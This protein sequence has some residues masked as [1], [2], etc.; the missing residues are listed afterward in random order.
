MMEEL[1]QAWIMLKLGGIIIIPLVLLGILV[2]SKDDIS[3][4]RLWFYNTM[5]D[6]VLFET[7]LFLGSLGLQRAF[8]ITSDRISLPTDYSGVTVVR[9]NKKNLSSN[10]D[11]IIAEIEKTKGSYNLKPLPAAALAF[12]YFENF[13]LPFGAKHYVN[14][15]KFQLKIL[16]PSNISDINAQKTKYKSEHPSTETDGGRPI[17]YEY[18]EDKGCYWDIPTT[19]STIYHLIDYII[20]SLEIGMNAEREDWIQHELRNFGGTLE[21]LIRKQGAYS[22]NIKIEYI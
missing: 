17:A 12:G 11:T 20:P 15:S 3:L 21:M 22:N 2:A 14:N 19:L 16:I 7:G 13:V 10:I 1:N 8:L 18:N 9:Y 4:K 6:N 5:R